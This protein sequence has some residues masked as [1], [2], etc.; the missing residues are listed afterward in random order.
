MFKI[1]G[2]YSSS[3]ELCFRWSFKLTWHF[4]VIR[5]TVWIKTTFSS[6]ITVLKLHVNILFFLPRKFQIEIYLQISWLWCG[7]ICT[8]V[9]KSQGIIKSMISSLPREVFV[10]FD[11]IFDP[12]LNKNCSSQRMWYLLTFRLWITY[13]SIMVFWG[14]YF[15]ENYH[16]LPFKIRCLDE[17][18]ASQDW[19]MNKVELFF[20]WFE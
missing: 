4:V 19:I 8:E 10:F 2:F 20:Q 1:C 18:F 7:F 16:Q 15:Q 6:Y 14:A 11:I 12:N 17:L 5:M 13:V 3:L 9:T